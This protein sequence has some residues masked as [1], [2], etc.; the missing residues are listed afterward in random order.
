MENTLQWA[1]QTFKNTDAGSLDLALKNSHRS[2][3][4]APRFKHLQ[5]EVPL[6]DVVDAP[7][8]DENSEEEMGFPS[9][10]KV[11]NQILDTSMMDISVPFI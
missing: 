9:I 10:S 6:W 7:S 11:S 1:Q 3:L 8:S 5:Q 4:I 2:L